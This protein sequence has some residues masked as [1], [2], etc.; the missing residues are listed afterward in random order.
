MPCFRTGLQSSWKAKKSE[1]TILS[2]KF[3]MEDGYACPGDSGGPIFV[4]RDGSFVLVG[5]VSTVPN[6][7]LYLSW[8]PPCFCN[9]EDYPEVHARVSVAVPWIKQ[10]MAE[11]KLA[12]SCARK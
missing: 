5:L 3:K 7:Q 8:P 2:Q 4:E 1:D 12:F 10:V 9:C 6:H 11:N